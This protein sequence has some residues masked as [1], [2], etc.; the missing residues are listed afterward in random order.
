MI[1]PKISTESK[2]TTQATFPNWNALSSELSRTATMGNS[3]CEQ[4]SGKMTI[5]AKGCEAIRTK[6]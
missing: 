1:P 4:N 6:G 2:A 3:G 5:R